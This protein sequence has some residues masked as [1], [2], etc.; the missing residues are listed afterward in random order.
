MPLAVTTRITSEN[1]L[2]RWLP[3]SLVEAIH[4][5]SL[6]MDAGVSGGDFK[7]WVNGETTA[8]IAWSAVIATLLTNIDTAI[9]ALA[10]MA[11]GDIVASGA[12]QS[13]MVLTAS[14]VGNKYFRILLVDGYDTTLTGGAVPRLATTITTQGAAWVNLTAQATSFD[15]DQEA[16]LI[17]V[18]AIN[19]VARTDLSVASTAKFTISLFKVQAATAGE[20]WIHSLRPRNNGL[21]WVFPEGQVIGKENYQFQALIETGGESYPDHEKVE[22]EITGMRQG[23]FLI[24]RKSIYRG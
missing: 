6:V 9:D 3:E 20:E 18:T 17:D 24:P 8:A 14:G 1:I 22:T 7:L 15:F 23:A 21:I 2:V 19:E 11:V 16:E 4:V 12:D 10:N 13:S 5:Q